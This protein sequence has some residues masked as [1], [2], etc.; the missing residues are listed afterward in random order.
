MKHHALTLVALLLTS[1]AA[2]A[3]VTKEDILKL[4]TARIG[5]GLIL[6]YIQANAPAPVLSADDILELKKAGV[7]AVVLQTLLAN[8]PR[9][10]AKAKIPVRRYNGSYRDR[11]YLIGPGYLYSRYHRTRSSYRCR[12]SVRV[13]R[14]GSRIRTYSSR[15]SRRSR[16]SRSFRSSRRC[17]N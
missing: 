8:A 11:E 12:P 15:Y 4:T 16:S 5:D 1:G 13:Y 10:I 3:D 14:S 7:S 6:S 9:K 2:S 17:R